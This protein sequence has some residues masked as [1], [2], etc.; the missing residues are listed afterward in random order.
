MGNFFNRKNFYEVCLFNCSLVRFF[1]YFHFSL[2]SVKNKN[3]YINLDEYLRLIIYTVVGLYMSLRSSNINIG[4]RNSL[5]FEIGLT[6]LLQLTIFMP[7]VFRIYNFMIRK[8]H[9]QIIDD[10]SWIDEKLTAYGATINHPKHFKTAFGVTVFYFMSLYL[11]IGVD[12]YFHQKY[13]HKIEMDLMEGIF[14]LIN[15][16]AYMNYQ[17]T[18]ML[19]IDAVFIRFKYINLILENNKQDLSMIQSI[20]KIHLRLCEVTASINCCYSLNLLNF[21]F[22]FTFFNIFFYFGLLHQLIYESTFEE[23]I[24]SIIIFA[25]VQFFFW[26]GAWM[27]LHSALLKSEAEN[28]EF[29]VLKKML[30]VNDRKILRQFVLLDFQIAHEKIEVSAGLFRINWT[31]LF[32]IIGTLFSYLIILLQFDTA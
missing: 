6:I 22:Q 25:Y 14:A 2:D 23:V 11:T 16:I 18:H 31:F 28:T 5:I 13:L 24:F 8:R 21:F 19:I 20:R 27:I 9:T 3:S 12:E 10:I 4:S 17:I 7:T 1:G 32:S 15:I 30:Y 29:I 26:F